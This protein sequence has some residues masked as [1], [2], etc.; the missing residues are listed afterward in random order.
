MLFTKSLPPVPEI[1]PVITILPVAH[2]ARL[3]MR[4]VLG[5]AVVKLVG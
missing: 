1:V 2:Q 4:K 5:L 3:E